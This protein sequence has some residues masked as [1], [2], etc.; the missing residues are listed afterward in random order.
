MYVSVIDES[1]GVSPL[2]MRHVIQTNI[3]LRGKRFCVCSDF[4]PHIDTV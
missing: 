3:Y 1:E 2:K 4:Y